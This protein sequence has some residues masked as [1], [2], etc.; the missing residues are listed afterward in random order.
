MVILWTGDIT[1]LAVLETLKLPPF[2]GTQMP[3]F[4]PNLRDPIL[5]ALRKRVWDDSPIVLSNS[6]DSAAVCHGLLDPFKPGLSF[7]GP[8]IL[9]SASEHPRPFG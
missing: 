2:R 8:V 7:A 9:R 6:M 1:P 3:P 5:L 4:D